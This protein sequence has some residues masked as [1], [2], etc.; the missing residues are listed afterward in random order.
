MKKQEDMESSDQERKN[1]NNCSSNEPDSD[2]I[3]HISKLSN[4]FDL[5]LSLIPRRASPD[6]LLSSSPS[7]QPLPPNQE[8]QTPA[9]TISDTPTHFRWHPIFA[10]TITPHMTPPH[11]A[12]YAAA[13]IALSLQRQKAYTGGLSLP[14]RARRNPSQTPRH[15]KSE[16]IPPPFPWATNNRATVHSLDFLLSKKIETITGAVQCKRCEEQYEL[17]F[18]LREKFVEVRTFIAENKSS[19]HHRAPSVWIT[20]ILPTCKYCKQ[21]NSVKPLISEKKKSINWLFL[22]L[23]QT[24]GCCTLEQ[25]NYF[26]KHS[27]NH[28]T[29]AKGRVLYLTYLGICKQLDPNGP[30]DR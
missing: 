26:C 25:L 3:N 9:A 19:M 7:P 5:D 4:D 13:S 16:N 27:K 23:G 2:E 17:G 11:E 8:I 12:C 24:L 21:E 30:F 22:L 14:T 20:P 18:N 1:S 10:A 29:G 15:G 28:G 6:P